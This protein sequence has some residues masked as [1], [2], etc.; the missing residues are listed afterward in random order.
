MSYIRPVVI[1]SPITVKVSC[2]TEGCLNCVEVVLEEDLVPEDI[3]DQARIEAEI[4][5]TWPEGFYC[6]DHR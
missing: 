5:H 1:L 4:N 6:E 2:Q 3:A